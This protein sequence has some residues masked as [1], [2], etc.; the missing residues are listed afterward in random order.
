MGACCQPTVAQFCCH[1]SERPRLHSCPLCLNR[2]RAETQSRTRPRSPLLRT[3]YRPGLQRWTSCLRQRRSCAASYEREESLRHQNWKPFS[4]QKINAGRPGDW[5]DLLG[6]PPLL[7]KAR[8]VTDR[9][10]ALAAKEV[11]SPSHT[12]GAPAVS[13]SPSKRSTAGY[14]CPP[15]RLR[16][17]RGWRGKR[18][19]KRCSVCSA[20]AGG[21]AR[22]VA[23]LCTTFGPR[24]VG[25]ARSLAGRVFFP[26]CAAP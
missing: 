21:R 17:R 4:L 18:V 10:V 6:S 5:D 20:R 19:G 13:S 7:A 23:R 3:E 2:N 25:I 15:R 22:G 8:Q 9:R 26:L 11:S 16:G 14:K 12:T 24:A 1:L